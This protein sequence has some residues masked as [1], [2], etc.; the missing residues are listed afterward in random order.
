MY[1]LIFTESYTRRARKFIRKHPELTDQ[2]KKTL[3]LLEINPAHPSLR[4]HKIHGKF[5]DIYS[6]SVNITYRIIIEFIIQEST[7]I[8]VDIGT[9]DEVY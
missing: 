5:T 3:Q 4:L 6:V 7:I 2:Y 9:H 8:P 1:K